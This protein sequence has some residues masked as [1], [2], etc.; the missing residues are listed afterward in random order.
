MDKI[1]T[2][3]GIWFG[4]NHELFKLRRFTTSENI[5]KSFKKGGYFFGSHCRSRYSQTNRI[6][7]TA[8]STLL[9]RRTRKSR[10]RSLAATPPDGTTQLVAKRSRVWRHFAC[11]HFRVSVARKTV[12]NLFLFSIFPDTDLRRTPN[13]SKHSRIKERRLTDVISWCL[14]R[15][16]NDG[17]T[18]TNKQKQSNKS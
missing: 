17:Q 9:S 12:Q 6:S 14:L 11:W 1:D 10:V 16:R 3:V 13:V 5:A 15:L 2:H 8:R 18:W 4:N 7:S